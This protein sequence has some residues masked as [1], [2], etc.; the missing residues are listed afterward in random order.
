MLLQLMGYSGNSPA[1]GKMQTCM[2]HNIH[3]IAHH[4]KTTKLKNLRELA[5]HGVFEMLSF[6]LCHLTTGK[7]K[8]FFTVLKETIL[9]T[10]DYQK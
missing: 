6:C 1:D 7:V 3:F 5:T 9:F 2:Y 8:H 10:L 4:H